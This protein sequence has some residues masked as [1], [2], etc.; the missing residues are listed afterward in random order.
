VLLD[1]ISGLL[2]VLL[3]HKAQHGKEDY[4]G[5]VSSGVLRLSQQMQH[6][7]TAALACPRLC[8]LSSPELFL[9]PPGCFVCEF[10]CMA[11]GGKHVSL[12]CTQPS[13]CSACPACRAL[14]TA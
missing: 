11:D 9:G 13:G 7:A 8:T 14:A 3:D 2:N 12:A 4:L 5:C 6:A 1:H 10:K